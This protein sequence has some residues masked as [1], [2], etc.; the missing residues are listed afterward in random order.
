[1]EAAGWIEA[2][3]ARQ[4]CPIGVTWIGDVAVEPYFDAGQGR[5]HAGLVVDLPAVGHALGRWIEHV[6]RTAAGAVDS[7]GLEAVSEWK[8]PWAYAGS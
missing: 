5:R 3:A 1:M 7:G 4:T 2:A 6:S 8:G